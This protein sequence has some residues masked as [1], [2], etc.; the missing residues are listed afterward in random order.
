VVREL[1]TITTPQ[2]ARSIASRI[3]IRC[4]PL[5][6]ADAV[7]RAHPEGFH[8]FRLITEE[9]GRLAPGL[10]G[11]DPR[12]VV[13]SA[14]L[15]LSNEPIVIRLPATHG[16]YFNLT[17]I[18][19]A[20]ETFAS[21]GSRSGNDSG[22]DLALVGPRWRGELPSGLTARRAPS[23]DVWAVSRIHAYCPVDW[24]EALFIADKQCLAVLHPVDKD[25]EGPLMLLES[26]APPCL[27]QIAEMSPATFFERLDSVLARAPESTQGLMSPTIDALRE[28][29]GGPPPADQWD[30]DFSI[31][32]A[33]GFFD[34]MDE[35]RAAARD[36]ATSETL[37][38]RLTACS[39][40]G[41][42]GAPLVRAA[43]A[44]GHL[45]AP[46]SDDLQSYVCEHDVQGRP[47]S[48]AS[49]YR[50]RFAPNALPPVNAFWWLFA[51]SASGQDRHRIGAGG[52]MR[53][54]ADGSL[55]LYIQR[56]SP[57]ADRIFNWLP[58]PDGPFSLTMNLYSPRTEALGGLWR[59]PA[60]EPREFKWTGKRSPR[61][62]S[63]FE[64]LPT[65]RYQS[66]NETMPLQGL[67]L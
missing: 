12:I 44:Q 65:F 31:A 46:A 55:E 16:R 37:G 17:L 7:R 30:K 36:G 61:S 4:F 67:M 52:D 3:F 41:G 32:L 8:Q 57:P 19:S 25:S 5:M 39:L 47:L 9:G 1:A 34:A 62:A 50:L 66:F 24:L 27:Q 45:G 26:E 42:P 23:N 59:M 51:N 10:A 2:E 54:G 22:L 53:L 40:S 43:R 49:C 11:S 15:D 28:Q 18:D 56:T 60:V 64:R 6:L 38:W 14:W 21:V 48:G 13:T 33:A 29:I 35:I 63:S 20:G 58:T